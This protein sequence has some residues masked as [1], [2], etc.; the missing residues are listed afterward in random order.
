MEGYADAGQLNHADVQHFSLPIW[1]SAVQAA[2][3]PL[4]RAERVVHISR[5]RY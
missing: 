3:V 4:I 5:A 2:P 1:T